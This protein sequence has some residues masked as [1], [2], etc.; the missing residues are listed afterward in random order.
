MPELD[1]DSFLS[2]FIFLFSFVFAFSYITFLSFFC[3][4]L[5]IFLRFLWNSK[6]LTSVAKT[7][8]STPTIMKLL[9]LGQE[10]QLKNELEFLF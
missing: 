9:S 8:Q 10:F 2:S 3:E 1:K 7:E 5:H 4:E 6:L